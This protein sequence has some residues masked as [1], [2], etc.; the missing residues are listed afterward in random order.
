[1]DLFTVLLSGTEEAPE[2][3]STVIQ[4]IPSCLRAVIEF[5]H[6]DR[7]SFQERIL[8]LVPSLRITRRGCAIDA[9]VIVWKRAA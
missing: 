5:R 2:R 9:R 3:P 7:R 1:V 4:E 6:A 8:T